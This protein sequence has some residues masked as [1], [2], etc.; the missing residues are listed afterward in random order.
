MQYGTA[1][2]GAARHK[3][4]TLAT[5]AA[6]FGESDDLHWET[7]ELL[8]LPTHYE[9]LLIFKPALS[10]SRTNYHLRY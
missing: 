5:D 7:R 8:Y 1:R 9:T 10:T 3:G 4:T 6:R 2:R